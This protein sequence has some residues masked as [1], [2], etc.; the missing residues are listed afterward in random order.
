MQFLKLT[1]IRQIFR[2][3]WNNFIKFLTFQIIHF[4][5]RGKFFWNTVFKL[6]SI[7]PKLAIQTKSIKNNPERS[8]LQHFIGSVN[9]FP[10]HFI[11]NIF[12]NYNKNLI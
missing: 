9:T 4:L 3:K 2:K 1:L 7:F 12:K 10:E 11:H 5:P 6:D 8:F